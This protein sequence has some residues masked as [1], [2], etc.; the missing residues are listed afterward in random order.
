MGFRFR[1]GENKVLKSAEIP[2]K[3]RQE[4]NAQAIAE[5]RAAI[6]QAEPIIAEIE[7]V[8]TMAEEA[9]RS[10]S[11]SFF[12]RCRSAIRFLA[13]TPPTVMD[14]FE[15][16]S[17]ISNKMDDGIKIGE[18]SSNA[19]STVSG[20]EQKGEKKGL[21]AKNLMDERRRR[22]KLNVR[23][24]M[25][26]FVVPKITKNMPPRR[27]LVRR[28]F[29][30][31]V[32]PKVPEVSVSPFVKQAQAMIAIEIRKVVD[33][34]NPRMGTVS[35]RV[36]NFTRMNPLEFHGS[37]VEEDPQE[38]IY[39]VYKIVGIIGLTSVEKAELATYKLKEA[40]WFN[41]WKEEKELDGG[42]IDWEKFKAKVLEFIILHQGSMSAKK[43]ALKFIQLSK[44]APTTMVANSRARMSKFVLVLSTCW[45]KNV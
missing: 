9:L 43:Y 38:L 10:L 17:P 18:N 4:L 30:E 27:N 14:A 36:W 13:G 7:R 29:C 8:V 41:Q 39:E 42:P 15:L 35:T 5:A 28:N 19:T 25:L 11:L 33:P 44:Y 23:L 16:F 22:K 21:P 6:A 20:A 32:E 24:Y 37:K 31:N 3:P 2:R 45:S 40:I 34:M 26:R 12:L 1:M